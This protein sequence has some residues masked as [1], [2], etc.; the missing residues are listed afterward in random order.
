MHKYNEKY[1][2]PAVTALSVSEGG[3][4]SITKNG[5]YVCHP[6]FWCISA[7]FHAWLQLISITKNGI[8][9]KF[10]PS[11]GLVFYHCTVTLCLSITKNGI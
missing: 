5:I 4:L 1:S 8:Y 10:P 2:L 7:Y 3:V 6:P 9:E 11:L